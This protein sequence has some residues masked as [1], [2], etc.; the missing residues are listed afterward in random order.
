M[1]IIDF[2]EIPEA[3]S[4]NGLQ[5][6]FE[7][8]A[9]EFLKM[10]GLEIISGPDR[11][12]DGGRDLIAIESRTGTIGST[13]VKWLVSCKHKVHS[14]ESVKDAD[15]TNII[16]RVN[17]HGASGFVGFYSTVIS[18]PLSRRFDGL[19]NKLEI[20]IFDNELIERELL[21]SLSGKKLASR[22]FPNSYKEY[23]N[24]NQFKSNVLSNYHPLNCMYCGEDLLQHNRIQEYKGIIVFVS[25]YKYMQEHNYENELISDIYWVCKGK[26]DQILENR[27]R[28]IGGSTAWEDISDIIIPSKYLSWNMA[29]MNGIFNKKYIY[30]EDAFEKLKQFIIRVSQLTLRQQTEEQRERYLELLAIPN[31]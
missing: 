29:I 10:I 7:L 6:T 24:S 4:S 20:K 16:D 3:N 1:P 2:K 11:G 14:G 17:S 27:Y 9:R 13:S 15:E 26:C 12:Q 18:S 21:N 25:N 19:K 30:T 28:K 31:F 5:D 8:F 23:S 22:F